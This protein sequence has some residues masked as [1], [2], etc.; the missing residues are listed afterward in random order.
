MP[1]TGLPKE[2]REALAKTGD[3]MNDIYD[4]GGIPRPVRWHSLRG[5]K[6]HQEWSRLIPWVAWLTDRYALPPTLIPPCW[7]HHG[8]LVE[9]L[10]AL[11]GAYEVAYDDTQAATAML[12][13][14]AMFAMARTRLREWTSVTGCTR[15]DHRA[16]TLQPWPD[17]E[18][19][20]ADTRR[21]LIQRNGATDEP[22]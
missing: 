22:W 10:T 7:P 14:H 16:A 17:E 5:Q 21:W 20:A 1:D 12:D 2:L 4:L 3:P 13:W 18:T 9:E 15:D 11:R 19:W 6:A 8:A